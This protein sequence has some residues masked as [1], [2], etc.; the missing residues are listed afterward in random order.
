MFKQLLAVVKRELST[1]NKYNNLKAP[2]HLANQNAFRVPLFPN[3]SL[4]KGYP[5]NNSQKLILDV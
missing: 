5:H 1:Q 2:S 4:E 3:L